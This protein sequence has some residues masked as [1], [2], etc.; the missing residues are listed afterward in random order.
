MTLLQRSPKIG[1]HHIP[2][3]HRLYPGIIVEVKNRNAQL[4]VP[5]KKA[6]KLTWYQSIIQI[7]SK[8]QKPTSFLS[9]LHFAL[10]TTLICPSLSS[11][12]GTKLW[13]LLIYYDLN[14]MHSYTRSLSRLQAVIP[15]STGSLDLIILP[16][17]NGTHSPMPMCG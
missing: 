14:E 5:K 7:H 8:E 12:Y 15:H 3:S 9:F 17:D 10:S 2:Y 1:S 16:G 11:T 4:S 13:F 6:L